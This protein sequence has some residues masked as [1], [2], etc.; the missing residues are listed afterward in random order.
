MANLDD[1]YLEYYIPLV[2][3]FIR[4][5]EPLRHPDIKGMPGPFLPLFG[6]SYACS[7]LKLVVVGQDTRG[8]GDLLEFIAAEKANPGSKLVEG[9]KK[10]RSYDFTKWG[11]QRQTFW[12]F[13][14]MFLAA[15]HG[16]DDWG[17]MKQGKMTEILDS[18][19]WG[20]G[21]AVEL[22]PHGDRGGREISRLWK[23]IRR[24]GEP[25]NRFRHIHKTLHPNVVVLMYRG[26]DIAA[27]FEGY[28]LD[29]VSGDGRLTHYKLPEAGVDVFHVPHPGSM[30]R[31]EKPNYFR[32]KLTKLFN[33][34]GLTAVF[35]KFS[36]GQE[37]GKKAIE[38]LRT[39]APT[40]TP[41]FDKYSFVT[42]VAEELKKRDAFMSVPTLMTLVNEKGG[43]TN[44]GERFS[45]GRGSYRLVS[46][47]YHRLDRDGK[48]CAARTVAEAFRRPNFE[49]AYGD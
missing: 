7:A 49:Y 16:R 31:R 35:D 25:L 39:N 6:R 9:L 34:Y 20:N 11:A 1:R 27:Y 43:R 47:T 44:Y 19:A 45:G 40:I 21:N 15:L 42:W 4:K 32:G 8:W 24:A 28:R 22:N 2:Q 3:D 17:A 26:I 30:N 5:V 12:G 33:E 14:M 37:E 29:E 41:S 48:A 18:F 46:G 23:S 38:Y 13:T 10:F 36:S